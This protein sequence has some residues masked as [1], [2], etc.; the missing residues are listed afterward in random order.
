[1]MLIRAA[2][3]LIAESMS[4]LAVS[5]RN[6]PLSED[7]HVKGSRLRAGDRSP[8]AFPFETFTLLVTGDAT[9][10]EGMDRYAGFVAVRH[11]QNLLQF[12]SSEPALFLIRPDQ[13]LAFRGSTARAGAALMSY[14][15]R[16]LP[17]VRL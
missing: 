12:A 2:K 10:P 1:P 15:E 8:I 16:L 6:G 17:H 3:K 7:H 5:Y 4:Q 14:L 13:Y 11:E 9:A